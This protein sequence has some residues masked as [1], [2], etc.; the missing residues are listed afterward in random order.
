VKSEEIEE[1]GGVARWWAEAVEIKAHL[2][3]EMT[4]PLRRKK[5]L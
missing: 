5:R 3:Y 1:G 4:I 2:V